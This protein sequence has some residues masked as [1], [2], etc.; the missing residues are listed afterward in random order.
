MIR[1]L[2]L[3]MGGVLIRFCPQ[4]FVKRYTSD[5]ADAALLLREVFGRVEW[6]QLDR[7]SIT[8]EAAEA[9]MCA[10]LP[11]R[12]H[13]AVHGLVCHW[14]EP[15]LPIPGMQALLA[16]GK[17]KGV[18]LYLLSNA[19]RRQHEYWQ[20]VPGHEL[21][22]GTLIS[23]DWKLIK[24]QPEIYRALLATYGLQPQEC[25]FIDDL[26][27]NV[28]GADFA[29]IPGIVFDGGVDAL[30]TELVRRHIL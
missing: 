15:I 24:P 7:G 8:E 29:G 20:R 4:E 30:R 5:A 2:I 21:F 19:A 6:A 26:P 28:E 12:L 18:K 22:D 14:D 27:Q 23:A 13:A 17:A 16:E 10:R 25:L 11:A 1:N 9:A 3:D